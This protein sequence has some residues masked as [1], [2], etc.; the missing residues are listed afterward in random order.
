M[1]V[2][3]S[4][5]EKKN[6]RWG[7]RRDNRRIWS[8]YRMQLPEHVF[9]KPISKYSVYTTVK[10]CIHINALEVLVCLFF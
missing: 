8:K 2:D 7:F 10:K 4:G 1:E 9:K 5:I 3:I 6:K